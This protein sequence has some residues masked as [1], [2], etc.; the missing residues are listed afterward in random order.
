MTETV[1][2]NCKSQTLHKAIEAPNA[3]TNSKA[4]D[5]KTLPIWERKKVT[6]AE[7]LEEI[8]IAQG[9]FQSIAGWINKT[10]KRLANIDE[11]LNN[12]IEF[13]AEDKADTVRE[14]IKYKAKER[15]QG[16]R[17]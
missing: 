16:L 4:V 5:E 8:K 13:L 3:K 11:R 1:K 17:N 10:E 15:G 9:N 12:T 14:R 2:P 7:I 6:Q